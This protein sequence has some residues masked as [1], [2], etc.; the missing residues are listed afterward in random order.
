[1]PMFT[2]VAPITVG[3]NGPIH[4]EYD[5]LP[6]YTPSDAVDVPANSTGEMPR[7][8]YV[9]GAGNVNVNLVGGGT[10]VLTGLSAGQVVVIAVTRVLATSTTATAIQLLY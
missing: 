4:P 2:T 8:I 3:K 6:G 5:A 10:A 1:M 7:A 9:G